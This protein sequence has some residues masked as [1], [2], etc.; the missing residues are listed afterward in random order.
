MHLTR[1]QVALTHVAHRAR[2][3]DLSEIAVAE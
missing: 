1:S 2:P 3:D